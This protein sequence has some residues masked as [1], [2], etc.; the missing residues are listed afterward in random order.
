MSKHSKINESGEVA[1]LRKVLRTTALSEDK[2]KPKKVKVSDIHQSLETNFAPSTYSHHAVSSIIQDAFPHSV[3]KRAGKERVRHVHGVDW[4]KSCQGQD[5]SETSQPTTSLD[6][7]FENRELQSRVHQLEERVRDLEKCSGD[8][9][10]SEASA[11]VQ[12][13][14]VTASGPDMPDHLETFSIDTIHRLR[15]N[16]VPISP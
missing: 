12:N 2:P 4:R 8:S 10:S 7:V 3:T 11:V 14:T 9:F 13:A 5:E 16:P 6:A 1:W 15:S